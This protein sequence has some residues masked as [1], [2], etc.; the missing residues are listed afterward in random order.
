MIAAYRFGDPSDVRSGRSGGRMAWPKGF[1]E[2]LVAVSGGGCTICLTDYEARYLQIDHRVPFQVSGD[3]KQPLLTDEF[4]L[5]CRS[6]NRAKSWSCEHCKNWVDDHLSSVCKTCYWAS[7]DQYVHVALRVMRRLEL[8][9]TDNEVPDY[10]SL[11]RM[12]S[13]AQTDLP[14]YVK[15]VLR[16]HVNE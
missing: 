13:H 11:R 7:P 2:K 10:D 6:C 5:V 3:P 9:W 15:R 14:E 16:L 12:S 8:T 4:M 1:K